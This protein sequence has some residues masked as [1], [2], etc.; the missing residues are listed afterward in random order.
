MQ[1]LNAYIASLQGEEFLKVL[2]MLRRSFASFSKEEIYKVVT[3]LKKI[4]GIAQTKNI[5]EVT[6]AEFVQNRMYDRDMFAKMSAWLPVA[7]ILEAANSHKEQIATTGLV[8]ELTGQDLSRS[9]LLSNDK[10]PNLNAMR[11]P[12]PAMSPGQ[13]QGSVHGQASGMVSSAGAGT[14]TCANLSAGAG[15]SAGAGAGALMGEAKS[16]GD[17][18]G[19]LELNPDSL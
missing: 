3:L 7:N 4:H 2:V 1:L 5:F 17:G 16:L 6:D 13:G 10:R 15:V 18:G 12:A 19:E 14:G 11:A 8:E 9:T